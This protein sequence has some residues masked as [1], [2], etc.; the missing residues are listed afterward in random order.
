MVP[1][2]DGWDYAFPL[3]G[4]TYIYIDETYNHYFRE[5]MAPYQFIDWH[6]KSKISDVIS[7]NPGSETIDS[8]MFDIP[9]HEKDNSKFMHRWNGELNEANL[10]REAEYQLSTGKYSQYTLKKE[11]DLLGT[12][13]F[14]LTL[15]KEHHK[16][17]LKDGGEKDV[18]LIRT[19]IYLLPWEKN[20]FVSKI[21]CNFTREYNRDA[22]LN[23]VRKFKLKSDFRMKVDGILRGPLEW[24]TNFEYI[25]A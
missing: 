15:I 1:V 13:A 17:P 21:T 22:C 18:T 20:S 23:Y 5:N 24:L 2:P 9:D 25:L 3:Y 4:D 8:V 10:R 16:L 11:K 12:S 19:K 6:G 14:I 7:V